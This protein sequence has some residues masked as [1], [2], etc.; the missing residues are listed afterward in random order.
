MYFLHSSI[1]ERIG[2]KS[3]KKC[4]LGMSG[5]EFEISITFLPL[6]HHKLKSAEGRTGFGKD[7][8]HKVHRDENFVF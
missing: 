4:L 1:E 8:R 6:I 2:K 5:F 3:T 7:S